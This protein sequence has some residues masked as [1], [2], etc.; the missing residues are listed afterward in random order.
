MKNASLIFGATS[1]LLSGTAAAAFPFG[2][3]PMPSFPTGGPPGGF[4]SGPPQGF[5]S[6]GVPS[7][8]PQGL[9]SDFPNA[10]SANAPDLARGAVPETGRGQP[11]GGSGAAPQQ[12]LG[13]R[14][15]GSRDNAPG[16]SLAGRQ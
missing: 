2:P 1:A 12:A 13:D 11:F 6:G 15:A 7:G 16:Q 14:G 5:P 10:P 4:P 9:P 3:P 8:P